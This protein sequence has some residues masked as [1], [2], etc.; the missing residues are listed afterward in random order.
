MP[1]RSRSLRLAEEFRPDVIVADIGMPS[2]DGCALVQRLRLR[3]SE[4]RIPP[5]AALA[6][7]GYARAEDRR[8]ALSA[9]F[10]AHVAKPVAPDALVSAILRVMR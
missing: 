8:R 7:T 5:F 1:A 4:R 10:Q 9:G 2:E 6:L 3:E